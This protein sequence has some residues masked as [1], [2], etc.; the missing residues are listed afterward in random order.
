MA[1]ISQLKLDVRKTRRHI[2]LDQHGHDG[3]NFPQ[4]ILT[5]NESEAAIGYTDWY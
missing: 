1:G 5:F 3:G 4:G 2:V